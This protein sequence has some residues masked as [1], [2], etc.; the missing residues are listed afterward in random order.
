MYNQEQLKIEVNE[1]NTELKTSTHCIKDSIS[2]IQR[3]VA[4]ISEIIVPM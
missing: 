3:N 2:D 4:N 1:L